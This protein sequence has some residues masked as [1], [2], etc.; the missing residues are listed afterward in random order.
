MQEVP[1]GAG[2]GQVLAGMVGDILGGTLTDSIYRKTGELKFA[3]RIVA[4][5][6]MLA[7]GAFL[8]PAGLTHHALTAVLCLT[9]SLFFLELVISP[10]W[11]APM[12]VEENLAGPCL[13]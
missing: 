2:Q 8:I 11:A 7:A 3:R 9:G 1:A 5:P 10:A 4:A 13:A 6:A 12:D